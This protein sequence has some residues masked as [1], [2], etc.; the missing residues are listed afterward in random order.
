MK[1]PV[2]EVFSNCYGAYGV[3]AAISHAGE[4]GLS[5][6]EISLAPHQMGEVNVP[7]E[8]IITEKSDQRRI[9]GF[10]KSLVTNDVKALSFNGGD[11]LL[12]P[13]GV[14]RVK[15]R[16]ELASRLGGNLFVAD[17]GEFEDQ[18]QEFALYDVLS[19]IGDHAA[20]YGIVVALETHAGIT[21]NSERINKTM[22][23]V[24]HPNVMINF[25]T[26]NILFYNKGIDQMRE[27]EQVIRFVA[28]M[29]LKDSRGI[30]KDWYFPSLGQGGAVDFR[31]I[32]E[33]CEKAGYLGA[34]SV[35]I[36]GI[37]G[38]PLLDL[39][40]RRRRVEQS[41]DHLRECGIEV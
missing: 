10:Q 21:Q 38:E 15:S 40:G 4:I 41:L 19:E 20:S 17:G 34:F 16:I 39:D 31:R 33:M 13:D 9:E 25:D 11:D 32:V 18:R 23:A 30:F 8:A 2:I 6:V 35:E 24:A 28:H 26:A 36:E 7:A 14:A 37:K 1:F 5:H 27:L 22:H 3:Q 29:H 12:D